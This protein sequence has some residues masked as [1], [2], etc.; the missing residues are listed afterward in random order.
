LAQPILASG[1]AV[2]KL[3]KLSLRIPLLFS[4]V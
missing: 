2:Q 1:A 4:N 3:D